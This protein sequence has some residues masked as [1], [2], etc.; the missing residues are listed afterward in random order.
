MGHQLIEMEREKELAIANEDY[1]IAK[2]L[3]YQIEQLQHVALSLGQ[4]H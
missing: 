2:Q 1:D 3:K 4:D